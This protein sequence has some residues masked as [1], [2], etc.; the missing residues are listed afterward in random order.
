MFQ[1]SGGLA[2]L[3]RLGS[4][5]WDPSQ[6]P[7]RHAQVDRWK[8]SEYLVPR[9][10]SCLDEAEQEHLE[11][12][13]TRGVTPRLGTMFSGTDSAVP[14][15]QHAGGNLRLELGPRD[16]MREEPRWPSM[17]QTLHEA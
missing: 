12:L 6:A 10:V 11:G 2:M 17:D 7:A 9:I 13:G 15:L 5:S 8:M 1:S 14:Y 3:S 16:G 4:A